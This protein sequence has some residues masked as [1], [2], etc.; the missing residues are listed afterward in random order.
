MVKKTLTLKGTVE[1]DD[2]KGGSKKKLNGDEDGEM[3]SIIRAAS[4]LDGYP[5]D[6]PTLSPPSPWRDP[7]HRPEREPLE[8]MH[9][10]RAVHL[11]PDC[12]KPVL[13]MMRKHI[14]ADAKKV[15]FLNTLRYRQLDRV[16]SCYKESGR[17]LEL[18][19]KTKDEWTGWVVKCDRAMARV[20]EIE[21]QM[22]E[23]MWTYVPPPAGQI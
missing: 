16:Q 20:L 2:N 5:S 19:N 4:E 17:A 3:S 18:I 15:V 13:K 22:D 8:I 10:A 23:L 14:P 11:K 7:M 1:G 6:C 12:I 9:T 21:K